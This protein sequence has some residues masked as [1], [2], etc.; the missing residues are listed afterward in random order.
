MGVYYITP[1][2]TGV[3][4]IPVHQKAAQEE[5]LENCLAVFYFMF[6]IDNKF[7]GGVIEP[8]CINQIHN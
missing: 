4:N 5:K 3:E 1:R 7:K 8:I 2:E 6:E